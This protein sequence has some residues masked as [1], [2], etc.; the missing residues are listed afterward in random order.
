MYGIIAAMKEEVQAIK[1]I[2]TDI[3]EE[4]IYELKFII[5]KIND[6]KVVL[7]ES[8]VGKVNAARVTQILINTFCIKSVVNVGV[9][10][11]AN[12]ELNIGDIVIGNRIVQHDFDITA[13][14]HPKGY[15]SNIG[16]NVECDTK[17]LE[18]MVQTIEN[19]KTKDFKIKIGVI[20]SGDIF[21]VDTKMKEK[22]RTK[23][24]AEAID[25]ESAAIAQ[26]CTLDKIPL[27]VIRSISDNP[28]GNNVITYEEFLEMA[29]KRC[30]EIIKCYL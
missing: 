16:E 29:T 25:M 6:E 3:K 27:I 24:Q 11:A 17:L 12:N 21:C 1:D 8:G 22:I 10:G 15:I 28:N 20:A 9:A 7:V 26:V 23:F 30:A 19:L 14:G 18:K 13:F 4:E 2:M 5:G